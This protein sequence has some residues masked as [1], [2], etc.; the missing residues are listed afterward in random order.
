MKNLFKFFISFLF[1]MS[2]LNASETNAT[3][4]SEKVLKVG[5]NANYQPFEYVKINFQI[6]GFDVDL[7]NEIAKKVGFKFEIIDMKFENLIS[8]IENNEV[9]IAISAISITPERAKRVI[10]SKPYFSG[11]DVYIKRADN[12]TIKSK[13]D[14]LGKKIGVQ[15]GSSQE[16]KAKT[17]NVEVVSLENPF[18]AIMELKKNNIDL[19]LLDNV[20]GIGYVDK[21]SDLKILLE[22]DDN[23]DGMAIVFS[24]NADANFINSVNMALDEIMKSEIYQALLKKHRLKIK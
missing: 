7:I 13:S 23:T 17:L 2:A 22:E 8:A 3:Q 12:N 11:T 24:K 19:V 10:F 14:I 20:A 6:A 18:M 5:L 15:Q 4:A 21:N 16:E 1:L 9:D